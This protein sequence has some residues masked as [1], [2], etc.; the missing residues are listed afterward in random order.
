MRCTRQTAYQLIDSVKVI[1]NVRNC[2]Q[3]EVLPTNERQTRAL[4]EIRDRG[5]CR[6]RVMNALARYEKTRSRKTGTGRK[7]KS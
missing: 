3:T 5:L 7:G 4:M 1:D 6:D 2:A